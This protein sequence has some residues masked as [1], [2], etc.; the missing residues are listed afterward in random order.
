MQALFEKKSGRKVS[1]R[2]PVPDKRSPSEG[3]LTPV[4]N[5]PSTC[6][7]LHRY[8][9]KFPTACGKLCGHLGQNLEISA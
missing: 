2:P 9:E 8:P 3:G 5:Y 4:E 6:G 1:F 7:F